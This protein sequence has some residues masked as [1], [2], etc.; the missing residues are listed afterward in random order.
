MSISKTTFTAASATQSSQM[1]AF[2]NTY[3]S[4]FFDTIEYDQT[5]PLNIVCTVDNTSLILDY[6]TN[7]N[8]CTATIDTGT[9]DGWSNNISNYTFT[10]GLATSKGVILEYGDSVGKIYCVAI[11]KANTGDTFIYMPKM[12]GSYTVPKWINCNTQAVN[13]FNPRF[14]TSQYIYW[15]S[16]TAGSTSLVPFI[17]QSPYCYS[18]DLYLMVYTNGNQAIKKMTLDNQEY[19][20]NGTIALSD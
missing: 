7:A 3:A 5:N 10:V 2:L 6:T 17:T 13:T 8:Y 9:E 1:Y 16:Q 12:D 20:T 19:A 4:S 11:S 18:K 14:L 15:Y